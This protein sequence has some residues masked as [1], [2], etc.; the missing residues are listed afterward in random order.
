MKK[1][2]ELK[3]LNLLDRFLF[4]ETVEDPEI[5]SD[6]LEIILGRDIV[7]KHLPQ[8]EKEERTKLW[9]KQIRL[10]VW[11]MDEDESIY[12]TEVQRRNT[13]NLPRRTRLYHGIIDSKLLPPGEIDYN[14]LPDVFIIMILPFDLFGKGLY[15]YTFR[16]M[17]QEAPNLPLND[18]AV[19]I[20]L[21]TR[22]TK[23]AGVEQELIDL[24]HY[25]EH[26]TAETAAASESERIHRLQ[27]KV[28]SI[29]SSEEMGAKFMNEWEE[30][31]LDRQ[32][33]FEEGK[34]QGQ[35][36]GSQTTAKQIARKMK[37]KGKSC[38]EIAEFTGLEHEEIKAL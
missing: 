29:R 36:Q 20:F 9:S 3:D 15:R 30:R 24:L 32:E 34:K 23:R 33:A 25:F 5:L 10:D 31:I 17:C 27:R 8:T 35:R 13:G 18:G 6:I 19:R 11:A 16:Q 14:K 2:K 38:E 12:E 21:N 4:A 26:S 28:E 7:L 37:E 1:Q 22:G